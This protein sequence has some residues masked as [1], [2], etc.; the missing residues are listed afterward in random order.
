MTSRGKNFLIGGLIA[1]GA[2]AVLVIAVAIGFGVWLNQPGELLDPARLLSSDATGYAEW[3]LRLDDPGTEGF[4]ELLIEAI[5][6]MPREVEDSLPSFLQVWVRDARND[7]VRGDIEE[8]LPTVVAWT[9]HPAQSTDEDLHLLSV[10]VQPMANRVRFA[11]W[12]AGFVL[13]RS[14]RSMVHRYEGEKIYQFEVGE[15]ELELTL[16]GWRG[17]LF[18]TT[19]LAMARQAVDLLRQ[20]GRQDQDRTE[21]ER[22]FARTRDT[23][24]LRAAIT[25]QHGEVYRL[26]ETARGRP[27]DYQEEWQALQGGDLTGGLRADGT[28]EAMIELIA[29]DIEWSEAQVQG[30]E[31]AFRLG[32]ERIPLEFAVQATVMDDGLRLDI[33][34]PNLVVSL[35]HLVE[36]VR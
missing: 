21:L 18:A 35:S 2:L 4:V 30:M 11:D 10:S 5:Q 13:D 14:D 3:T 27:I 34:V 28:F 31:E 7:Q 9:L 15:R 32:L 33:R 19:D 24:P 25:N 20:D 12:M 23:D 6:E 17:A 22:L 1:F 26:L 36:R 16:F 29:P 8:A